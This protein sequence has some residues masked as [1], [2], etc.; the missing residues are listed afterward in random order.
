[1]L[2]KVRYWYVI[3]VSIYSPIRIGGRYVRYSRLL[4]ASFCL[5]F[6][7]C[8]FRPS[9]LRSRQRLNNYTTETGAEGRDHHLVLV[10]E[11]IYSIPRISKS[12]SILSLAEYDAMMKIMLLLSLLCLVGFIP[13]DVSYGVWHYSRNIAG[14]YMYEVRIYCTRLGPFLLNDYIVEVYT[15][16]I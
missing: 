1:M 2:L 15:P 5:R 6:S 9:H 14:Q 8:P 13:V 10:Q 7:H 11:R 12:Y 16:T 3:L 4:L